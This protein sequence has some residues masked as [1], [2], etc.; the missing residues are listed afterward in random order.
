MNNKYDVKQVAKYLILKEPMTP[1]RLQKLLYFCYSYYLAAFNESADKIE[2][3]LFKNNFQAWIHGP[4]LPE[5]YQEYKKYVMTQIS[6]D[7]EIGDDE[8]AKEDCE[9]IDEVR[10]L[11]VDIT[12]Y[13]ME[14]ITHNQL[15]WKNARIGFESNE[16]CTN[17]LSDKDIFL[18]FKELVENE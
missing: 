14:M 12:T 4:V 2:N 16:P 7:Q 10:Q 13:Q 8:I 15:P 11:F 3:R 1:K 17:K 5:I 9:F 6:I 18:T